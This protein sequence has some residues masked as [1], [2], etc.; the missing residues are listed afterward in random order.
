MMLLPRRTFSFIKAASK[1]VATEP[2]YVFC[3]EK[4]ILEV[5]ISR[6]PSGT[7]CVG[8]SEPVCFRVGH[9]TQIGLQGFHVILDSLF[10]FEFFLMSSFLRWMDGSSSLTL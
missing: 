4:G 1:A 8:T 3:E 5:Y 2:W 9:F 6:F 10:L 7:S